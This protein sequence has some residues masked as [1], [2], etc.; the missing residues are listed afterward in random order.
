MIDNLKS[1]VLKPDRY[2]PE[3]NPLYREFAEHYGTFIDPARV[4]RPR[5]KGKIERVVPLARELFRKLKTLHPEAAIAE[6]NHLALDWCRY[7]NGMTVHGTTDE[8]PADAFFEREKAALK[9][10]PETTFELATWK[11]VTVHPDQYIQFEKKPYSVQQRHVGR[12]LW[13]KGTETLLQVYD[14]DFR[15][16]KQ[17]VRSTRRWHTDWSDFPEH[18]QEMFDDRAVVRI[19]RRAERIGPAMGAYIRL[20]LEPH[21]KINL[22]KAQGMLG[23]AERYGADALEGAATTALSKRRFQLNDFR[24]LLQDPP[25]AEEQIP[26]SSATAAYI[27]PPGYFIHTTNDT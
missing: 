4:R 19:L 6:M 1:G 12:T 26:I 15:L 7:Q 22:R 18:V 23:F 11:R 8:K 24:R 2:D 5:D 25:E 3:L 21:A 14:D 17:H 9:P 13:A 16:L 27:R 10:L 20:I